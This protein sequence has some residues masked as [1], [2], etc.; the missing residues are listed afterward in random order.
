[1]KDSAKKDFPLAN[2]L[3][4]Y[5]SSYNSILLHKLY[6]SIVVAFGRWL[7]IFGRYRRYGSKIQTGTVSPT[8]AV[9]TY[10]EYVALT[11]RTN[12]SDP[13]GRS[14]VKVV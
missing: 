3:S 8:V 7:K 1:M 14:C 9:A 10:W 11:Q 5:N 13:R 2:N 4:F 6:N 12:R